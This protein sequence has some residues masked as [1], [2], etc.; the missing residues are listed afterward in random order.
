V[1]TTPDGY[2]VACEPGMPMDKV[3]LPTR[4]FDELSMFFGGV[5]AAEWSPTRGFEVASDPR[6]KGGTAIVNAR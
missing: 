3:N 4:P 5:S 1:E 6:R 2:R